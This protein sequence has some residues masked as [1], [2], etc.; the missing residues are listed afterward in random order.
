MPVPCGGQT[1]KD[2]KYICNNFGEEET[3]GTGI[4]TSKKLEGLWA[5]A[6]TKPRALSS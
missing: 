2:K 6:A 1:K 3:H 5:L 4:T